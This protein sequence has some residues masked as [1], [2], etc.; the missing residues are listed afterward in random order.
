MRWAGIGRVC[1]GRDTGRGGHRARRLR[2]RCSRT[3]TTRRQRRRRVTCSWQLLAQTQTSSST[4]SIPSFQ[5]WAQKAVFNCRTSDDDDVSGSSIFS[6][7]LSKSCRTF[8]RSFVDE[9]KGKKRNQGPF[10][11]SKW[12]P[13]TSLIRQETHHTEWT[14]PL[15]PKSQPV[16]VLLLARSVKILLLIR[17]QKNW[18]GRR[19]GDT[20]TNDWTTEGRKK[21]KCKRVIWFEERAVH[22]NQCSATIWIR[23][24]WPW[25]GVAWHDN[26]DD[27]QQE[28]EEERECNLS[29]DA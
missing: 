15:N 29:D 11:G 23:V 20:C 14:T 21:N 5:N 8:G 4:H 12:R 6:F 7:A 28:E 16:A 19:E 25:R 2:V 22:E 17:V 13:S 1:S 27:D 24:L 26:D 10:F 18:E 9:E 3:R